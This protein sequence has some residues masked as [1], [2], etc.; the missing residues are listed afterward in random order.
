MYDIV[1]LPVMTLLNLYHFL[2]MTETELGMSNKRQKVI[3]EVSCLL[4]FFRR[5]ILG[6]KTLLTCP[7]QRIIK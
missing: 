2:I 4:T 5:K 1:N 3:C 7:V 6:E